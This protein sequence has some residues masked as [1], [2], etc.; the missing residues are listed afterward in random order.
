[1]FKKKYCLVLML[2]W[3]Q[4]FALARP[5]LF[6]AEVKVTPRSSWNTLVSQA[7][8]EVLVRVSGNVNVATIESVKEQIQHAKENIVDYQYQEDK[9][10]KWL[11]IRFDASS[12]EHILQ[13]TGQSIW[14]NVRPNALIWPVLEHADQHLIVS[15]DAVMGQVKQLAYQRGI[16]MLFPLGG[17]DEQG[18]A[19]KLADQ[20]DLVLQKKIDLTPLVIL[21]QSYQVDQVLIA[22]IRSDFNEQ[23][24]KVWFV[25]WLLLGDEAQHFWES[26]GKSL[27]AS[28]VQGLHH[29]VDLLVNRHASIQDQ[30]IK[31]EFF[32]RINNI[33]SLKDY[34]DLMRFMQK[35][36][37]QI[38]FSSPIE[39][40]RDYLDFDVTVK[41]G[42]AE[43][44]QIM[45]VTAVE[46]MEDPQLL[47]HD[48]S[49]N[50]PDMIHSWK[51]RQHRKN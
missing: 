48:N 35:K 25:R 39:V 10:Q 12:V 18:I 32:L 14:G 46:K 17:I 51:R 28:I 38:T 13:K 30:A 9:Q 42:E 11:R 41:G 31:G 37:S 40:G 26:E 22:F 34:L 24:K 44:K 19:D 50:I 6:T 20:A 49:E 23:G 2:F 27:D 8:K 29:W 43:L 15:S 1:L 45:E 16:E 7:F 33:R 5:D 4:I 47:L 36:S 21:S 3:A